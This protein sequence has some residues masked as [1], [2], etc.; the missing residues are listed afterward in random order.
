MVRLG[1]ICVVIGLMVSAACA[2]HFFLSYLRDPT[3][4]DIATGFL[5]AVGFGFGIVMMTVG[6]VIVAKSHGIWTPPI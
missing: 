5:G 2:F 6:G 1:W 3:A 4:N